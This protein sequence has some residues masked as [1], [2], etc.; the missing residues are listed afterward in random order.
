MRENLPIPQ[1]SG[2]GGSRLR[3]RLPSGP[4]QKPSSDLK[5][6]SGHAFASKRLVVPC[7][8]RN[9]HHRRARPA[10]LIYDWE[11]KKPCR[12]Q[13]AEN[14]ENRCEDNVGEIMCLDVDSRKTDQDRDG[15]TGEAN[16]SVREKEN[17]KKRR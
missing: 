8:R 13:G 9:A 7:R 16:S 17:T 1:N 10:N 5:S 4:K 14:A 3:S 15:Q 2:H 6:G 12:K 11:K